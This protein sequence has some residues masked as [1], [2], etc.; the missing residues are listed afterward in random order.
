MITS[1]RSFIKIPNPEFLL[2]YLTSKPDAFQRI[3]EHYRVSF[4]CKWS[5]GWHVG[6]THTFVHF[7]INDLSGWWRN[8]GGS[9]GGGFG[10][11]ICWLDYSL[12][13]ERSQS[14]RHID[15]S[16]KFW[17]VEW[18]TNTD[19]VGMRWLWLRIYARWMMLLRGGTRFFGNINVEFF[20]SLLLFFIFRW[21]GKF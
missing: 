8:D 11:G 13:R 17:C 15:G 20:N 21:I 5:L 4:N 2:V 18:R 10:E 9:S 1:L 6:A 3:I 12:R 19:G 14:K 16:W 7:R